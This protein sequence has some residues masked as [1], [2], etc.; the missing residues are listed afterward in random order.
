MPLWWSIITF[1]PYTPY[2]RPT[3]NFSRIHIKAYRI[4]NAFLYI[5]SLKTSSLNTYKSI[6]HYLDVSYGSNRCP[7]WPQN[8]IFLVFKNLYIWNQII[9]NL[10]KSLNMKQ[11]VIALY[12]LKAEKTIWTMYL[13]YFSQKIC[14]CDFLYFSPNSAL[15]FVFS[16]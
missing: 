4:V 11:K 15:S 5:F 9:R 1:L 3:M 10:S 2:I 7:K 14:I 13:V 8:A 6:R 16:I 12:K